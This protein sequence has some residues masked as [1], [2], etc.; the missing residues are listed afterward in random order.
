[1]PH[2]HRR[3]PWIPAQLAI[4]AGLAASV[5]SMAQ[6]AGTWTSL[7]TG[8]N[9]AAAGVTAL[10]SGAVVAGGFFT[11]AGG[12][13]AKNV[14][15]WT[16][17][18]TLGAGTW[19][20]L[21]S[22]VGVGGAY[23]NAV[24]TLPN[25]DVVA[26][27]LFDTAGGVSA[28]DIA[29]WDGAAWSP[30]GPGL[31]SY[32]RSIR[33][34]PSGGLVAGG[35]FSQTGPQGGSGGTPVSR[36]A[37]WHDAT[38]W[39]ALGNG[40]DSVVMSLAVFSDGDVIAAG[41][42][43]DAGSVPARSIARWGAG[44]WS[45]LPPGMYNQFVD[46]VAI[47]PNGD[48]IAGG[49]FTT[50]GTSSIARIARWDGSSWHPMG[51]GMNGAVRAL[52]VLPDG[53]LIAGGDFTLA[54]GLSAPRIARWDGTAWSA[55]GSGVNSTVE[56]LAVL[57]GGDVIVGGQFSVAGGVVC[58]NIARWTPPPA[59]IITAQPAD[60]TMCSTGSASFSIAASG[61]GPLAYRWQAE[62]YSDPML[63]TDL[64]DGD[65][66]VDGQPF[67][68][69]AGSQSTT[70]TVSDVV[71]LRTSAHIRCVVSTPC[72]GTTSAGAALSI[73]SADF[74]GDGDV[75]TDSDI[76]AFFA[77]LAGNCCAACGSADFNGDGDVGTDADIESFFR[78][79]G[80]A[81]C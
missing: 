28:N 59:P 57:P 36:V 29:R 66:T 48:V 81:P 30:L 45:E 21:G 31:N 6:C 55:I 50:I 46:A 25:G 68:T 44:G 49:E 78:A 65:A 2:A 23:V 52:A 18:A 38:G 24:T 53:E 58:S 64:T 14:A 40:V 3:V 61:A 69:I 74:N 42:F 34:L 54:G 9:G 56:S 70:L 72:A 11:S 77:C 27:G 79:L 17:G 15:M 63:W 41:A 1:M 51:T 5:P 22:G 8:L 73:S 16:P 26:G 35:A 80:G 7:G 75:G 20:A 76:E 10:P 62:S 4:A 19:S 37:V 67:A 13:A 47:M 71:G 43:F 12:Q 39:Q 32:I 33:P 60:S